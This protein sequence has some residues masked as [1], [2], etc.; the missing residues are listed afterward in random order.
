MRTAI[1]KADARLDSGN[2]RGITVL[3]MIEKIFETAVYNRLQFVNEAFNKKDRYNGGFMPGMRTS[4]NMFILHGL[5]QRQISMGK[6][7][8]LCYIDFSRAFDL[9]SRNILFYKIMKGGWCGRV[10]DT[11]RD[12]YNKTHFKVKHNGNLSPPI[13]QSIGVNQGG[14]ASGLLFR[15]YM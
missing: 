5:T 14:V 8:Y 13:L 2:Y 10:I 7:L 15:K 3:P 6:S 12:L 11:L 9:L 4:D 1:Y